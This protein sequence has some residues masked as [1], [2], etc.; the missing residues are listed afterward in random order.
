M[1]NLRPSDISDLQVRLLNPVVRQLVKRGIGSVSREMMVVQWTGRKSGK[2]FSTP[3]SRFAGKDGGVFMTTTASYKHNFADGW[4]AVLQLGKERRDAVGHLVS[5]P[6]DVATRLA[7][8]LDQ[9][10][11]KRGQRNLGLQFDTRPTATEFVDF[12][13]DTG[14]AVI[15]FT[16]LDSV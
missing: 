5:N 9:L 13:E 2:V 14:W 11:A 7:S 10:G 3:V 6:P 1:T 15:D 8:V 12:V 4:P 16:I